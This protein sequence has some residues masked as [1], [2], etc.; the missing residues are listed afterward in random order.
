MPLNEAF[1]LYICIG[2]DDSGFRSYRGNNN[3]VLLQS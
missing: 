2:E 1:Q 3:V